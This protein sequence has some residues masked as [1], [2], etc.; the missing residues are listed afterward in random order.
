MFKLFNVIL[1]AGFQRCFQIWFIL[2]VSIILVAF[3]IPD[4]APG[5][6]YHQHH[7]RTHHHQSRQYPTQ[8]K[9]HQ[10]HGHHGG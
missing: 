6:G 5:Q 3:G 9:Q 8:H 4:S 1:N 10:Q 7:G 2:F